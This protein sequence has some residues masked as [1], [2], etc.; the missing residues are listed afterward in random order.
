MKQPMQT[1]GSRPAQATSE[2][3]SGIV[4]RSRFAQSRQAPAY[5]STVNAD[6]ILR[7]RRRTAGSLLTY[8]E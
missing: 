5:P 6:E 7:N 8:R 1:P 3:G 2:A 4:Y